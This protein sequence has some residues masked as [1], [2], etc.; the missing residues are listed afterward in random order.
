MDTQY[1]ILSHIFLFCRIGKVL[2]IKMAKLKQQIV[3]EQ[4]L[5][6]YQRT[7]NLHRYSRFVF[8]LLCYGTKY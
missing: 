1:A 5:Q 6:V 8:K 4:Y 7:V 2:E 3:K